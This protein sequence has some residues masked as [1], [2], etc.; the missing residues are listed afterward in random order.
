MET[1][2]TRIDKWLWSVRLFKTRSIAVDAIKGGKVKLDGKENV[3][4]A[5]EVKIGDIFTVSKGIIT[6]RVKVLDKPKNR[7]GA[8]LVKDFL[9]DLTSAEEYNKLNLRKEL[10]TAFYDGK[11]RPTKK[12]RRQ[13][14]EFSWKLDLFE[15]L[16][17]D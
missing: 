2:E 14:D 17:D 7:V 6:I 11:G 12:E 8:P 3:K 15:E 10:G 16:N 13:L 4:P 1:K 5:R 9:E